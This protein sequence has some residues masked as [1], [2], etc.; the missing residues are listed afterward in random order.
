[1]GRNSAVPLPS[2]WHQCSGRHTDASHVFPFLVATS[3]PSDEHRLLRLLYG[4]VGFPC[5][6]IVTVQVTFWAELG[7]YNVGSYIPSANDKRV[8]I[9]VH[10]VQWIVK[11]NCVKTAAQT[12]RERRTHLCVLPYLSVYSPIL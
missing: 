1:M 5:N 6:E 3:E 7:L 4:R 11:Y 12:V 10:L 2:R 9:Y 8:A